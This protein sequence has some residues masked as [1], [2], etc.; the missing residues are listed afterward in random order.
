MK[1]QLMTVNKQLKMVT[2]SYKK[3]TDINRLLTIGNRC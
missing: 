3:V 1:E 2:N